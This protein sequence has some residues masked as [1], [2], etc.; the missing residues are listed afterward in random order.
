MALYIEQVIGTMGHAGTPGAPILS[1][2]LSITLGAGSDQESSWPVSGSASI[3]Q[4][5]S[6]PTA[7]IPILDLKGHAYSHGPI[8]VIVLDGGFNIPPNDVV[9]PFKAVM[10]VDE[11]WNG[12]GSFTY[13]RPVVHVPVSG[14]VQSS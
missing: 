12:H 5:V 9:V 2:N 13:T 3:T 1:F 7:N 10:L 11:K 8:I 14:T 6:G 4:S